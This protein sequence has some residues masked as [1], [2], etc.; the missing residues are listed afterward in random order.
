MKDGLWNNAIRC[1]NA[2]I[3]AF[4]AVLLGGLLF[5]I[6]LISGVSPSAPSAEDPYTMPSAIVG[7]LWIGFLVSLAVMQTIT[8]RL[9]TVKVA[10]HP[11]TNAIGSFVF[12]CGITFLLMCFSTPVY[13]MVLA[14]K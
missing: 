6:A 13:T 5:A 10:F 11:V 3:A 4:G 14:I 8:D 2:Y 12:V 9:S 1:M 7:C